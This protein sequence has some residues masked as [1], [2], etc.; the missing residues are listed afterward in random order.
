MLFKNLLIFTFI[1]SSLNFY[2]QK[3]AEDYY[4]KG[5]IKKQKSD[6]KG[7]IEN[8]SKAIEL[9]PK[10][11]EAYFGR[12]D[13]KRILK[14]YKGAIEDF[15]KE[16]ELNPSFKEDVMAFFYRGFCK[17]QLKDYNGAIQDYNSA[18]EIKIVVKKDAYYERGRS[19]FSSGDKDGAC[20]DW[21]K[22]LELGFKVAKELIDKNC[23]TT[24]T[25]N[26][27]N[28]QTKAID[29]NS[30]GNI[31]GGILFKKAR[32]PL[33]I[34]LLKGNDTLKTF[35]TWGEAKFAHFYNQGIKMDEGLYFYFRKLSAS[36]TG[37]VF[38]SGYEI[39]AK[40]N[41][42]IGN[43]DKILGSFIETKDGYRCDI[44]SSYWKYL[45]LGN[46]T[47]MEE[48]ANNSK[49]TDIL[50][51]V[52]YGAKKDNPLTN[53]KVYLTSAKGDTLKTTQTNEYGDF[54]FRKASTENV[55]IVVGNSDKIKNEKEI[56]LA[57]QNGTIISTMKK[58]VTGF[59]YRML[60]ADV[61]KL[62]PIEEED[63]E[64]KID[65]FAKSADK[66]IIVAENIYYPTNEYKVTPD[67]AKKLDVIANNL[68]KNKSYKLEIYSHTDA[69]GDD[70]ANLELSNKRSTA[71]LDYM[72]SKGIDKNRLSAKGMGET[73]IINR[74]VNDVSCSEKEHELNRR[75]EFKFIK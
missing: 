36:E 5:N 29:N 48:P 6:Y 71:V 41:K 61:K 74:C 57:K 22:A 65:A 50:A 64:M 14:D 75:T 17:D 39:D 23:N 4:K 34:Y 67:I 51:K 35:N 62:S 11:Y 40:T 33:K 31:E 38:L 20:I 26:S 54:E 19:K 8:Y 13:S 44:L 16:M 66:T 10:Y 42:R 59:S 52:L 45:Y 21:K 15:T 60:A 32:P 24:T 1:T 56:Y 7:A 47:K 53:N 55:I 43:K 12:A 73:K 25:N 27:D 2:G 18:I 68:I 3:T 37:D 49:T 70:A 63:A 9:K 58:T 69:K 30:E 46:N 28:N 72:V